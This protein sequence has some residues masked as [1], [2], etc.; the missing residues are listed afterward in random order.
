VEFKI[1]YAALGMTLKEAYDM[2]ID[3]LEEFLSTQTTGPTMALKKTDPRSVTIIYQIEEET[4]SA[5]CDIGSSVNALP[6]SLGRKLKLKEPTVGTENE[7]VLANQT[8]IKSGGTI[9]DVLV[10]V[11]D[12]VFLANF[13]ILYIEED[14]VQPII[15][16]RP[17]LATSRAVIDMDLTKMTL[18]REEEE[19]VI[20]IHT[21]EDDKCYKLE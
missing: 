14:T 19:L 5:L 16:G 3:E 18:R 17:F 12:L 9:E 1:W 20:K 11:E 4:V 6:L 15:L 13:M 2:F 21:K 10:K 8:T 7:L